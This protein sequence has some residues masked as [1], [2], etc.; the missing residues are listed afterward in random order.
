LIPPEIH[1]LLA[2]V[3]PSYILQ[4]SFI[5]TPVYPEPSEIAQDQQRNEH[6]DSHHL[7]PFGS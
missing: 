7:P 4:A 5:H 2:L 6:F 1:I 3:P